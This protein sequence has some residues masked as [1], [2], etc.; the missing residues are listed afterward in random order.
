MA[1]R[2]QCLSNVKQI[3]LAVHNYHDVYRVFPLGETILSSGEPGHAW[4]A[5][6]LPYLEQSVL[7]IN[8]DYSGYPIPPLPQP[9]GTR[10]LCRT[11]R[12]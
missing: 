9:F 3:G 10:C 4:A 7:P 1:R 2:S 12:R 8:Y 5:R 11:T 6:L